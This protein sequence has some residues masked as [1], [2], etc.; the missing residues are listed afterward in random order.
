MRYK[1]LNAVF[2]ALFLSACELGG[3]SDFVPPVDT[4]AKTVQIAVG[5]HRFYLPVVAV[6]WAGRSNVSRPC[7][8]K[9]SPWLCSVPLE[10][11]TEH[12]EI[13]EKPGLATMIEVTLEG[14]SSYYNKRHEKYHN[15]PQLC[16]MLSQ[17]WARRQ[18]SGPSL[19]RDSLRRFT[20]IHVDALATSRAISIGNQ[21]E[22]AFQVVQK[23]R[24]VNDEPNI[25]CS[26]D[27]DGQCT[28]A[29]RI[30][31]EVLVLWIVSG[32]DAHSIRRQAAAIR[33]FLNYAA[34]RE[35]NYDELKAVLSRST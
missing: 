35:E 22:S 5:T 28:A 9:D 10:T 3:S 31:N 19:F 17:R 2:L 12:S 20:L 15:I 23:M 18:C 30:S 34:G 14:Y 25:D 1:P 4:L 26:P 29:M 16:G 7:P 24:F 6:S 13:K 8:G 21:K 33:A 27:G 32:A 11:L